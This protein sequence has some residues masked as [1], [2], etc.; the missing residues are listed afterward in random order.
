MPHNVV[1]SWTSS[2]IYACISYEAGPAKNRP[3]GEARKK[4]TD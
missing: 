3:R 2:Q 4:M 1:A